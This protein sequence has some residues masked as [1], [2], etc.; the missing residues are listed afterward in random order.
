M[1]L[2]DPD[3][4]YNG[5]NQIM[6]H[7]LRT[8]AV[9][10]TVTALPAQI[11]WA[12]SLDEALAEAKASNKAVFIAI[13]MDGERANDQ[14]VRDHYRDATLVKLSKNTINL[15][16]SNNNHGR[17]S[18]KRCKGTTCAIHR[19]NDY[20]VRRKILKTDGNTSVIAPQ[21]LF[22]NG[23]GEIIN[24]ATYFITKGELE[25]LWVKAI[26][27]VQTDFEWTPSGRYRAPA[28]MKKGDADKSPAPEAPP[29]KEEVEQALK[30]IKNA[31]NDTG[32]DDGDDGDARNPWRKWAK[33]MEGAQ[34]NSRILIRSDDKRALSWGQNSLR[35]YGRFR[36][37]L[38]RDIGDFSPSPW[39]KLIEER[40]DDKSEKTR[41]TTII[42][43]EKIAN[44][45]SATKLRKALKKEKDEVLRGRILRALAACSPTN[46]STLRTIKK[47]VK[48]DKSE[49]IRS[50]AVVAAGKLENRDAITE[51]LQTALQD[52]SSKVRSVAAYVIGVRLD[53][54]MM[55]SLLSTMQA[56]TE[57]AVKSWMQKAV[58]AIKSGDNKAF[59]T[60]LAATLGDDKE[61]SEEGLLD[62]AREAFG[63]RRDNGDNGDN[64]KKGDGDRGD[65][66]KL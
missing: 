30:N 6:C 58:D 2:S 64:G 10:F 36:D 24:S 62:A 41:R 45:K 47:A 38:I 42:A 56:E 63:G 37:N 18:C 15:F 8:F 12:S 20:Q 4:K 16:C 32:G 7:L 13:N 46:S 48:S 66:G 31:N 53:K 19:A 54:A 34:K 60:F 33:R 3:L 61:Q 17:G 50:H 59:K 57:D 39:S 55:D 40:V 22:V 21:H 28:S 51:C 11:Q 65:K 43:L 49:I 26:G 23:D 14:M 5:S 27:S 52:E 1:S 9:L 25:W 44:P 29:T 35:S